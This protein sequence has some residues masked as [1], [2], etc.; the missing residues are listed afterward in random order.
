MTPDEKIPEPVRQ[1]SFLF[2]FI[3]E[4]S[5]SLGRAPPL[6]SPYGR[7]GRAKLGRRGSTLTIPNNV[8]I[9][10]TPQGPL[11]LGCAEPALPKGEPRSLFRYVS[12]KYR[13]VVR[14]YP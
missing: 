2:A 9:Q 5:D 8:L 10:Q 7:G 13:T 4:D 12:Q 6:A 1:G 14:L 11:S 3:S